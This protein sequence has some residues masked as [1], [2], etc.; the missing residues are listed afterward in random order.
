ML[1]LLRQRSASF[2]FN[3]SANVGWVSIMGYETDARENIDSGENIEQYPPCPPLQ[4]MLM[5]CC[6]FT[7][8]WSTTNLFLLLKLRWPCLNSRVYHHVYLPR[9]FV[10]WNSHAWIS[11]NVCANIYLSVPFSMNFLKCFCTS[12]SH[13]FALALLT[14][15]NYCFHNSPIL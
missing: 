7:A 10:L 1:R 9:K 3:H 12:F 6:H 13:C 8:Q 5:Y 2:L 11:K 15:G 4:A 14:P